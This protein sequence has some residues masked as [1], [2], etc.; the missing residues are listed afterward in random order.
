MGG[1]DPALVARVARMVAAKRR[2]PET[3]EFEARFG[4]IHAE[5]GAFVPGVDRVTMDEIV[6]LLQGS[7]YCVSDED[8]QEEHDFFFLDGKGCAMRTRVTFDS[9]SMVLRRETSQK[10]VLDR[11]D[12][13]TRLH[14]VRQTGM[15][16][17]CML[18]TETPVDESEVPQAVSTTHVRIKQRRRFRLVS[19]DGSPRWAFDFSMAWSGRTKTEAEQMQATK[20]PCFEIECE[21]LDEGEYFHSKSDSYIAESLL[22]KMHDLLVDEET[23]FGLSATHADRS[24]PPQPLPLGE[25]VGAF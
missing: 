19:P 12:A 23:V 22:C 7:S 1:M 17:R 8:W 16:V 15:D 14:G 25:P 10:R 11:V 13:E 20:D 3:L 9:D 21:L 24:P 18:K 6:E 4:S 2:S 5:R